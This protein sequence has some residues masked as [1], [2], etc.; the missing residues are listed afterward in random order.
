MAFTP[1][2]PTKAEVKVIQNGDQLGFDFYIPRGAKGDAGGWTST[3]LPVNSDLNLITTEG[4]YRVIASPTAGEATTANL[5]FNEAGSLAVTLSQTGTTQ[6]QVYTTNTKSMYARRRFGGAW[7]PWRHF[8][9]S[10]V[11]QTAGRV[12]YQWDEVNNRE[13]M[14]YG[15]TGWRNITTDILNGWTASAIL[16]RRVGAE[17]FLRLYQVNGAAQT[18]GTIMTLTA[19]FRSG[20]FQYEP[21]YTEAAALATILVESTGNIKAAGGATKYGTAAYSEV[22]W[23]TTET[24]PTTLPGVASGSIPT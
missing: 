23:S 12:M 11:D 2:D 21:C 20:V 19:G 15:D 18:A 22:R 8:G 17:V 6:I 14:I 10:R 24:W 16:I 1:A 7:G 3:A 9:T 5:P 4:L 13:Q